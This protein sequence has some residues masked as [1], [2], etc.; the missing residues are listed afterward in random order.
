MGRKAKKRPQSHAS[1]WH[2]EQTDCWYGESGA[3]NGS[4]R[5][6][7]HYNAKGWLNDFC[8]YCG[9]LTAAQLK[10]G[11]GQEWVARHESWKSAAASLQSCRQRSLGRRQCSVSRL[12]LVVHPVSRR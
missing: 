6:G 10:R 5:K 1:A 11:N 8:G 12:V 9:A 3:A 4:V 7:Y 2:W